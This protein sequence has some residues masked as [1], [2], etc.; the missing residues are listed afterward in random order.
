MS[1]QPRNASIECY[2]VLLMLGICLLHSITQG[3]YNKDW[4]IFGVA[5]PSK[6]LATCVNGFVFISGWYGI[7]T[8]FRKIARLY[9]VGLYCG[10]VFAPIAVWSGGWSVSELPTKI[11]GWGLK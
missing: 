6:L 9:L 7:R 10:L 4:F 3:P 1:K 2:R 8:N 5:G 11:I